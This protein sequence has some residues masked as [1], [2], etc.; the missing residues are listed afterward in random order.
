MLVSVLVK[1]TSFGIE[2]FSSQVEESA[3]LYPQ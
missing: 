3:I 1:L 2:I